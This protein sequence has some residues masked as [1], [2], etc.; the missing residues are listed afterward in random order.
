MEGI[1]LYYAIVKIYMIYQLN[2]QKLSHSIYCK[3]QLNK[4]DANMQ[5]NTKLSGRFIKLLV[6]LYYMLIVKSNN[7]FCY[8]FWFVNSH[9]MTAFFKY[10]WFCI[11]NQCTKV[12]STIWKVHLYDNITCKNLFTFKI[13]TILD[14]DYPIESMPDTEAVVVGHVTVWLLRVRIESVP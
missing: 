14:L 8:I 6:F 2:W 7:T 1:Q 10:D 4:H 5:K 13:A 3:I 11:R 12:L 9:K